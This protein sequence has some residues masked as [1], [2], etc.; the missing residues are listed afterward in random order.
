MKPGESFWTYKL[1]AWMRDFT[2]LANPLILI[3]VPLAVLGPSKTY[4]ILLAALLLNEIVGSLIKVIF[5]KKRPIGQSYKNWLEKIDAG[6][7]PSLHTSRVTIVYLT[8]FAATPFLILKV[9]FI[10]VIALVGFSRVFLKKH[11]PI[12]V[13]G[14]LICGLLIFWLS[15]MF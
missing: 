4:Y 12:D 9:L 5:P 7:F 2:S 3:F 6:S 14:G 13:L 1:A 15:T 8:L 10:V 11:F